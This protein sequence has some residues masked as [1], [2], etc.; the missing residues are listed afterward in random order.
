MIELHSEEEWEH[1]RER[2]RDSALNDTDLSI[3]GQNAGI[4]WPFK[5]SDETP[6]KYIQYDFEELK[7]VPGLIGKKARIKNLMN[8][9]RETLAF[10]DPFS[11]LVDAVESDGEIDETFERILERYNVSGKYPARF[12]R[13]GVE[14]QVLIEEQDLESLVA[15]IHYGQSLSH[16]VA[17]GAELKAFLNGIA[18]EHT[19]TLKAHLPYRS[20]ERGLYLAEAVGLVAMDMDVTVQLELLHQSGL[21]LTEAEEAQRKQASPSEVESALKVAVAKV[22]DLCTW[23]TEESDELKQ[24]YSSGG[25]PERYFIAI[26]DLRLERIAVTLARVHYGIPGIS[27][28]RSF[29]GKIS[30]LFGR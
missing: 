1:L 22:A 20:G 28:G 13:F 14:T 6:L 27:E 21:T 30:G 25:S 16:D 23:F 24:V 2:F 12:I 15:V 29:L 10:D 11:D 8:I 9:L 18:H 4:S 19:P 5:G 17:I 3:L 26:N 7:S